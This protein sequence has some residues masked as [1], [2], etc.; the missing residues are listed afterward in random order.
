LVSGYKETEAM[1][2]PFSNT[3]WET[4]PYEGA[5]YVFYENGDLTAKFPLLDIQSGTYTANDSTSNIVTVFKEI[6]VEESDVIMI[7]Y[8]EII[9]G[10]SGDEG[11][12]KHKY[13]RLE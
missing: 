7:D 13:K 6:Q 10:L 12:M 5:I 8:D 11:P 3:E 4:L 1:G 9:L 2:F